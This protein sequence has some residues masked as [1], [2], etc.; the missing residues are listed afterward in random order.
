MKLHICQYFLQGECKFGTSCK[1][2]HDFSNSETLE[3]LEKLGMSSHL[4]GRLPSIYRN[5]YDIKNKSSAPGKGHLPDL[6]TSGKALGWGFGIPS[7][8]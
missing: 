4:V 3:K 8:H 7:G 1:R 6:G 5:A 2:S